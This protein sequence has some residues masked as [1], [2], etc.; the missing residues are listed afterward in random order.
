MKTTVLLSPE[1]SPRELNHLCYQTDTG[2]LK[3]Q[4]GEIE[5]EREKE[6]EAERNF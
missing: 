5:R 6:K 4:G 3:D 2:V 1:V